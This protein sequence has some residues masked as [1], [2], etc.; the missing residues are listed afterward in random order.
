MDII[1]FILAAFNEDQISIV[2][3]I[4][5][6]SKIHTWNYFKLGVPTIV[7]LLQ[8]DLRVHIRKTVLVNKDS[9]F[10]AAVL[11][12]KILAV[13]MKIGLRIYM[14]KYNLLAI[15]DRIP[16][17]IFIL[18]LTLL[19]LY[20]DLFLQIQLQFLI[21]LVLFFI[22]RVNFPHIMPYLLL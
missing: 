5:L 12:S 21:I 18:D 9:Y 6:L 22:L 1:V 8:R 4:A 16:S 13:Q 15:D 20:P 19:L 3:D 11:L 14:F 2:D 17:W 10:N 7:F